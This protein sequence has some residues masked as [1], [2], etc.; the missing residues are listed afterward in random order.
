MNAK[1][2]YRMAYCSSDLLS[3]G[4]RKAGVYAWHLMKVVQPELFGTYGSTEEPVAIFNLN[5]EAELFQ[6][7]VFASG[8]NEKLVTIGPDLKELFEERRKR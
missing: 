4:H 7:H 1:I 5:S 3:E 2:T 6:A 8:L